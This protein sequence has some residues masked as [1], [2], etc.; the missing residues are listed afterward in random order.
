MIPKIRGAILNR[1]NKSNNK[2]TIITLFLIFVLIILFSHEL[3][4]ATT[5]SNTTIEKRKTNLEQNITNLTEQN[6]QILNHIISLN[7]EIEELDKKESVK[8]NTSAPEKIIPPNTKMAYLTFDDG[9]SNNTIKILDILQQHNIKATFFVVGIP[10][11]VSTYQRIVDEGHTL[12]LHSYS[13]E[14]NNIYK[15]TQ[16]FLADIDKLNSLIVNSTGYTPDILRF[17]GGSNNTISHRYGGPD[18]MVDI[19]NASLDREYIYF[20]WNVDSMDAAKAL[21]D[22]DVIVN[23]VINQSSILKQA[24]ILMHDS[25]SKTSTPDALPEIITGLKNLGFQFDKITSSTPVIQFPVAG[26]K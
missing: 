25:P 16:S 9:P 19:I 13:H 3:T 24:I 20:D 4:I 2:L 12:A 22:K 15:N 17:P 14:Y 6:R 11:R 1:L 23:S 26:I 7:I 18:I 21:Q 10:E 8:T 5:F